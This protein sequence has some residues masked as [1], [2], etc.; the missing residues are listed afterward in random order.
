MLGGG[1]S[2]SSAGS[3]LSSPC[4]FSRKLGA[5]SSA[6]ARSVPSGCEQGGH[7]GTFTGAQNGCFLLWRDKEPR[8]QDCGSRGRRWLRGPWMGEVSKELMPGAPQIPGAE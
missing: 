3:S 2:P 7:A 4:K 6:P 1:T 8:Q 5:G